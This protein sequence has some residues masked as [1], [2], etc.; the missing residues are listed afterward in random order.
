M[1]NTIQKSLSSISIILKQS[2]L[3]DLLTKQISDTQKCRSL[4]TISLLIEILFH[5]CIQACL[6]KLISKTKLVVWLA[7]QVYPNATRDS[8]RSPCRFKHISTLHNKLSK[9]SRLRLL[10][11]LLTRDRLH[12]ILRLLIL[13]LEI[14]I[15]RESLKIV[16]AFKYKKLYFMFLA[17]SCNLE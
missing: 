5:K 14:N 17:V 2:K 15:C 3:L 6:I 9:W 13:N 11:L 12:V 10:L 16:H 4:L 8:I 7:T 1:K